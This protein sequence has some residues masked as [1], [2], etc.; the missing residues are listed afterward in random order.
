MD[1]LDAE[2][3]GVCAGSLGVPVVA[4]IILND[5]IGLDVTAKLMLSA[6]SSFTTQHAE[7]HSTYIRPDSLP[8]IQE[9]GNLQQAGSSNL[10]VHGHAPALNEHNHDDYE[11]GPFIAE[12]YINAEHSEQ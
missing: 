8:S 10:T 3:T 6:S 9:A 5:L 1:N 11:V 12:P 4:S 2:Q 7:S